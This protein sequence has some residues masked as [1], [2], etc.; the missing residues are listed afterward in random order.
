MREINKEE[1][2]DVDGGANGILI[3]SIVTALITFVTG[4]LHGYSNPKKCNIEGGK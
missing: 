2:Y 1:M 4:I 3:T